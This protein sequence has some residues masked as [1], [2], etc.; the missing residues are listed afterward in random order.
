MPDEYRLFTII[1][2][3]QKNMSTS[4]SFAVK[5]YIH[6]YGKYMSVRASSIRLG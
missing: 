5:F 3:Y 4:A 1:L 6:W 2:K